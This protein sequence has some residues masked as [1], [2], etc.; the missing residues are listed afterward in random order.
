MIIQATIEAMIETI[1][2]CKILLRGKGL[3]SE[4]RE[5]LSS[6]DEKDLELITDSNSLEVELKRNE[7]AV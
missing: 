5:I 3:T 4:E 2:G 6:M 7:I 1:N